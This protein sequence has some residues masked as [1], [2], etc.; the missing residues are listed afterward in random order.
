MSSLP[1]YEE[2]VGNEPLD[3]FHFRLVRQNT[4]VRDLELEVPVRTVAFTP[5]ALLKTFQHPV[6]ED[7]P[8]ELTSISLKPSGGGHCSYATDTP[9][10][11]RCVWPSSYAS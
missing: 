3:A 7:D 6:S 4:Y 11:C 2:G 5:S 10:T 8:K 9:A 1:S